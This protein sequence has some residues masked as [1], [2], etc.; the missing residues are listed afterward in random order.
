VHQRVDP[1]VPVVDSA[2]RLDRLTE[3]GQIDHGGDHVRAWC[4]DPVE[5]DHLP[6]LVEQVIDHR[7][8]QL[9][10]AA[11]HRHARHRFSV[12]RYCGQYLAGVG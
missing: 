12:N 3:V 7:P 11:G 4:G 1:V 5:A 6:V 8:S 10:A 9:A 2:Q